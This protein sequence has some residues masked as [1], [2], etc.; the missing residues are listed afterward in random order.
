[1]KKKFGTGD[2]R[3]ETPWTRKR[4]LESRK[5]VS[6]NKKNKHDAQCYLA[7]GVRAHHIDDEKLNDQKLNN[8]DLVTP[9]RIHDLRNVRTTHPS[10]LY[11]STIP[12]R[13][14]THSAVFP[15]LYPKES[16][17]PWPEILHCW[18]RSVLYM[19]AQS[20]PQV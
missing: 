2:R 19:Q 5:R 4:I 18:A 15:V 12:R 3:S 10:I 11:P 1:M 7:R 8:V 16:S 13:I 9:I 6:G 14:P 17:T 20:S